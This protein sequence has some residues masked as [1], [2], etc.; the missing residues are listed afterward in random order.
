[1]DK[2]TELVLERLKK[3]RAETEVIESRVRNTRT[4]IEHIE[5]DLEK[6]KLGIMEGFH[7]VNHKLQEIEKMIERLMEKVGK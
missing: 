6:I 2:T 3:I 4:H 5:K 1:M 7:T